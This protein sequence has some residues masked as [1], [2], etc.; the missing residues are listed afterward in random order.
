MINKKYILFDLDGTLTDPFEGITK[1]LQFALSHFGIE[2]NQENLKKFIGPPLKDAF[3]EFYNFSDKQ[4]EKAIEKYR[5]RFSVKG[6]YENKVYD[7]IPELLKALKDAG[8]VIILATSKPIEMA[9]IIMHYF[10]LSEYFDFLAGST[11]NGDRHTKSAVIGY[12]LEQMKITDTSQAVMVGDRKFDI[13][14]AK[15]FDITTIGVL[16]GYGNKAEFEV[17]KADYICESIKNVKEL[18]LG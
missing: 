15:D 12:A 13:F 8:K 5:E 6:L 4:T 9:E 18:L 1:S 17:A 3:I 11:L 14:G 2:E 16:Y 10:G 7:G